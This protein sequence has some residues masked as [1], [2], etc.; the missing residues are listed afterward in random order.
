MV[1]GGAHHLDAGVCGK[2]VGQSLPDKGGI[3]DDEDTARARHGYTFL[4][5]VGAWA[6]RGSDMPVRLSE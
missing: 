5:T 4:Y 3:V 6:S 2:E 1:G